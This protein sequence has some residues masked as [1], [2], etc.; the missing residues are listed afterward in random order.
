MVEPLEARR[1]LTVAINEFGGSAALNNPAGIANG[2]DGN[3]WFT[4]AN[5]T[6]GSIDRVSP[7]GSINQ[8]TFGLSSFAIPTGIAT[9]PDG[10]LWFTEYGARSLGSPV[11][12]S[13]IGR[14]DPNTGQITEYSTN[15]TAN[16]GPDLITLGPDGDLWF[17]ENK[18]NKIGRIN[19]TTHLIQEFAIPTPNSQPVG[20]VTGPDHALWFAE[21]NSGQIG[22]I[23]PATGQ[24]IEF[25][26]APGLPTITRNGAP[27]GIALGPDGDLW[28]TELNAATVGKITT[29]GIV[30]QYMKGITANAGP[31]GIT[32]GPDG[33]LYFTE[34]VTGRV[35]RITTGGLVTELTQGYAPTSGP[36]DITLGPDG[37][38]W[39][40]ELTGTH[41]DRISPLGAY[42]QFPASVSIPP[43]NSVGGI[44]SGPD[45]NLWFTEINGNAN[46]NGQIGR[47]DTSGN[48]TEFSQGIPA[49][50][51]PFGITAGPDGNLWFTDEGTN[52]IGRITTKG[53][54]TEFPIPNP[55]GVSSTPKSITTGPDGNL[56]FTS[57][58]STQG[59]FIGRITP[60]GVITRFSRG[61]PGSSF[62]G[63][64]TGGITTG[65]DGNL[66]FTDYTLIFGPMNTELSSVGKITPQ[67][68]IT[69]FPL[70]DPSTEPTDIATGPD[71]VLYFTEYGIGSI[72]RITTA[73]ALSRIPSPSPGPLLAPSGIVLGPDH[74]LYFVEEHSNYPVG[75]GGNSIDRL[76][77][78]GSFTTIPVPTPEAVPFAMTVGPDGN[79][80][81][82]ESAVA[83]QDSVHTPISQIGQVILPQTSVVASPVA[84]LSL[85]AG[86][87]SS[88]VFASFR[89]NSPAALPVNFAATINFGDGQVVR[90]PVSSDGKG[91]FLV[92]G[93]HAYTNPGAYKGVVTILNQGGQATVPFT[94]VVTR[95]TLS[96]VVTNANDSGVGSLRQ[97]ILSANQVGGHP[98]T[99]AIPG[100]PG[101]VRTIALATPLPV[102]A[103]PTTIDGTS[104]GIF[105]GQ[106]VARP[107]IQVDGR[108]I[109]V[110]SQGLVFASTATNSALLD[111]SIFGFQ[112]SQVVF[113]SSGDTIRGNY[114]GF[115]ADPSVP[116]PPTAAAVA[117]GTDPGSDGLLIRGANAVVGGLVPGQR[118]VIS[119]NLGQ[120]IEFAGLGGTGGIVQGNDIGTDPTGT[121]AIPNLIF[122]II[123]HDLAGNETIGPGN[124]ISGNGS[125]GIDLYGASGVLIAGNFIGTDASGTK[126][127]GN[128]V[129]GICIDGG[130]TLNTIGGQPNVISGNGQIG[131]AIQGG[132]SQNSVSS[133]RIGTDPAGLVAIGNGIAG[134]LVSESPHNV[135]GPGNVVSGNGTASEGAGIW[136][137][138]VASTGVYVTGNRVGTDATGEHALGNSIIGILVNEAALNVIGLGPF[139][140]G[141]LVSGNTQI[142]VMLAGSGAN[143][144]LVQGNSIGTNL[145]GTSRLGNGTS[146]E[147][148]GVYLEN[149]PANTIGGASPGV[150]NLI[151]G[152]G[153]DGINA[154][155][156]GTTGNTIQGNKIGTNRAGSG[157]LGNGDDGVLLNGTPGNAVVGN[158]IAANA[159]DGITVAGAGAVANTVSNNRIGVGV[160]GRPLGNG[161]FGILIINQARG[162]V[163]G[164]NVNANNGLGPIRD[165]NVNPAPPPRTASVASKKPAHKKAVKVQHA[166]VKPTGPRSSH[167]K[168][169]ASHGKVHSK[170]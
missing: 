80:Y 134:V 102:I 50:S 125:I 37:N 107:L 43:T 75:P 115:A 15:L 59:S 66:W 167:P 56:W 151:S 39:F 150:A 135:I 83:F 7:S 121:I 138:G 33:N 19:P 131:V 53:V 60:Q 82:T 94:A 89:D 153:F 36:A 49:G 30:T 12:A 93:S 58:S 25:G 158:V 47:M 90:A 76:N 14:L 84:P 38:L 23:D 54:I 86:Q 2:P 106:V 62:D 24:V 57:S 70:S 145:E 143:H 117:P 155:G 127:L 81:F 129:T 99:F 169:N 156:P 152:N 154:F 69:L 166:K 72:G 91:G 41:V 128:G 136:V 29:Q 77:A 71:G 18:G 118:N 160:G 61:L 17:T 8:Y 4:E 133:N 159:L 11:G 13:A 132:S 157:P 35:A 161:H 10:A 96:F 52:A 26:Q 63:D 124:V 28:F 120:G 141:N 32:P 79:L 170:K 116:A 20:I 98:I 110:R 73:G 147:G 42:A 40:T 48:I 109:A 67:G 130:S 64:N 140:A 137:E 45:G 87:T 95:S 126:A 16:S 55:N 146:S 34:Q 21:S 148:A 123:V 163:I 44:T 46:G 97:A 74:F 119:G 5:P 103:G 142:G 27:T 100:A 3:L 6:G 1:L 114:I 144:N 108:G 164:P 104:Q 139:G 78:D 9:G 149:A 68:V 162:T 105:G 65:P 88:S 111:L 22:R 31:A 165:T 51:E 113:D 101:A 122:G 168:A 85:T 92:V 112:S